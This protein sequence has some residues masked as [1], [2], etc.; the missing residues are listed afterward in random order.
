M[1]KRLSVIDRLE[2][3]PWLQPFAPRH[4]ITLVLMVV[5]TVLL[6]DTVIIHPFKVF[7]VMT[8][9]LSHGLAAILTGGEIA[10]IEVN[11]TLGGVAYTRGGIRWVILSAGYVGSMF[12]G[13][14]LLVLASRTDWDRYIALL[15]GL[16]LL[17]ISTLYVTNFYGQLFGIGGAVVLIVLFVQKSNRLA[18]LVLQYVGLTSI[19]YAPL[20]IYEDTILR[21]IHTSDAEQFAALWGLSG[22][23]WG[24]VW[25]AIA[26]VVAGW[27]LLLSVRRPAYK[28]GLR[29]QELMRDRKY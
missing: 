14:L 26:L 29:K 8:H 19:L 16:G 12:W 15:L 27:A 4:L 5:A 24:V 6:W 23:F 13:A 28:P 25:I 9:E 3:S 7:V 18:E 1:V 2:A 11:P 21:S 22:T 20:D 17:L 10:R